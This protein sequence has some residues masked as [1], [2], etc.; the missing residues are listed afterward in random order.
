MTCA[1]FSPASPPRPGRDLLC[2]PRAICHQAQ[3]SSR[4]FS[5]LLRAQ[6]PMGPSHP[7]LSF[8]SYPPPSSVLLPGQSAA[9]VHFPTAKGPVLSG[10][11]SSCRLTEE[12]DLRPPPA[13]PSL[14]PGLSV[15]GARLHF[16]PVA[17][18]SPLSAAS[19]LNI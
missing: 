18:K 10:R 16:S 8:L 6:A 17:D 7:C 1:H 12:K 11:W 2:V 4:V 9:A 5:A 14:C 13:F 19:A 3:G 15:E